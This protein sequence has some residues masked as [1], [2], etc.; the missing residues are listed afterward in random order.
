MQE[1]KIS[2][3]DAFQVWWFI[4]WR[5]LLTVIGINL[6]LVTIIKFTPLKSVFNYLPITIPIIISVL[7]QIFY[8][9]YAINRNYKNFRL[10]ASLLNNK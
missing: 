3:E 7:I 1:K 10:S 8:F 4:F 6:V 2:M 9:K 5:T